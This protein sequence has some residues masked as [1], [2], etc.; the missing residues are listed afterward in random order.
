MYASPPESKGSPLSAWLRVDMAESDLGA[1]LS[2]VS[3]PTVLGGAVFDPFDVE[4]VSAVRMAAMSHVSVAG[5]RDG[6]VAEDVVADDVEALDE[7]VVDSD[8]PVRRRFGNLP[9]FEPA[10]DMIARLD[11]DMPESDRWAVRL[12]D[13][14]SVLR[15]KGRIGG[16]G[17]MFRLAFLHE[18]M[19]PSGTPSLRSGSLVPPSLRSEELHSWSS[20]PSELRSERAQ[21][22][23]TMQLS[24]HKA[25]SKWWLMDFLGVSRHDVSLGVP[26]ATLISVFPGVCFGW[27][28]SVWC[29]VQRDLDLVRGFVFGGGCR[30]FLLSS[31]GEMYNVCLF[32]VCGVDLVHLVDLLSPCSSCVFVKMV[33]PDASVSSLRE[34]E[35][36]GGSVI[37]QEWGTP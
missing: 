14:E 6:V 33:S 25:C 30:W 7:E 16:H 22:V 36:S 15:V 31:H 23:Y 3:A 26:D 21:V 24:L 1:R 11:A 27:R 13:L 5:A 12:H 17:G 29:P 37:L 34:A 35:L 20:A 28:I 18:S 8:M 10:A 32:L 19:D 9:S 2:S 4:Q